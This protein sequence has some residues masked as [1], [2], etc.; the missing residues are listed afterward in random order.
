MM[1]AKARLLSREVLPHFLAFAAL[2]A[3]TLAIDVGLHLLGAVWIGR[4]LG[5]PGVL[6]IVGSFG[7]SLR[8]RKLIKRG[9][10]V[11]LLRLHERMA[12][13]GS[14]L[15][16][17]HAGIHFNAL[18]GWLATFAMLINV[19]SG[20]TGKFLL[21]HSLLRMAPRTSAP[22]MRR[23]AS[24]PSKTASPATAALTRK[25]AKG[26]SAVEAEKMM[27][28]DLGRPVSVSGAQRVC[29]SDWRGELSHRPDPLVHTDASKIRAG[30][31]MIVGLGASCATIP[32]L[33]SQ[34]SSF[35]V[36]STP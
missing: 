15:V 33:A 11:V 3:A 21:E 2:V 4:Y 17:V 35:E 19:G 14:L 36:R 31:G 23:R 24:Q 29:F 25:A 28:A 7:Y 8:K 12:W 18:L 34:V 6:L 22:S 30:T 26:A 20:L 9:K 1:A 13:V 16:L 32:S 10:P 5:I 27:S